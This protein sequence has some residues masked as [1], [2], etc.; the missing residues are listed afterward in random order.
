M[1]NLPLILILLFFITG[2]KNKE[3]LALPYFNTSDFTPLWLNKTD[4]GYK[5]LHTIPPFSFVDQN[6]RTITDKTTAGKIYVAN[7]FFTRCENICPRMMDNMKKAANAFAADSSVLI[8]SHS[9]TPFYDNAAV[10]KKYAED[11]NITNPNW[12][13]VTGDK[14]N[15]YKLAREGYFADTVTS[16]GITSQFLHTENFI[17]VDKNR[18]IRGVYNGTIELEV[19]NLI[20]HIKMLKEED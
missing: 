5:K 20:R 2:C 7:F 13:L 11:K 12:H 1:K 17:L 6:G 19:D 3:H 4:P 15:I 16:S 10:L 18:H 14:N 8:I 9:V